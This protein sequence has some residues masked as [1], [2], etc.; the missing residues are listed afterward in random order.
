MIR[1]ER[2]QLSEG[3]V[4]A[5][6]V[7][8]EKTGKLLLNYGTALTDSYIESLK[9]WGIWSVSV[10]ERYTLLIEPTSS[11]AKELKR[12]VVSEILRLAP[13]KEEANTSDLMLDVSRT[14]CR[15][16]VKILEN[17]TV[18]SFLMRIKLID[19][20][21]LLRHSVETCA[22]SLLVAGSLGSSEVELYYIG[23]A[24]L[25]HDLGLCEMPPLI[26][27]TERK[28]HQEKSWEEHPTYGYYLTKESDLPEK[29]CK[30][31]LH[32]HESWNGEGFP[33]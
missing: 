4:L 19:D 3:M 28:P 26:H 1:L 18:L 27:M 13:E 14:A 32:H 12:S 23:I 11:L 22:L 21:F 33:R 25:L 29:V 9:E 6:P 15:T 17:P 7:F 31:I 10:N 20:D 24:A 30:Y 16:T 2:F 5:E 8:D